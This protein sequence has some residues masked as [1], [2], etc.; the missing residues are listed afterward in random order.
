M[1]SL[2]KVLQLMALPMQQSIVHS[3][4]EVI[5]YMSPLQIMVPMI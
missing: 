3:V 1:H 2:S 5:T 4:H